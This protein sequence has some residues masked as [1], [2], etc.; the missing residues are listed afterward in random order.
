MVLREELLS[1]RAVALAGP[2][3]ERLRDALMSLGARIEPLPEGAAEE[4]EVEA[5]ARDRAPLHGLVFDA[6]A[7]F[8]GGGEAR[9]QAAL[10]Q[11][12]NAVRPVAVGAL[13]EPA[14]GAK[15]VLVAPRADAGRLARAA[16]A[17]LESL[18]R[19]LSVE[20]ARYGLTATAVT[21]GGG[22][23]DEEL[24][25]LVCFLLSPAGDYFSG[26]RFDLRGSSA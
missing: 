22:V 5:W 19:T 26:C 3:S 4:T 7:T 20:W 24:A 21:P 14:A 9:L 16:G 23:R 8:Q 13:I 18:A 17:A 12:W 2:V 10:G 25:E 6:G 11:A 15:I 1:D